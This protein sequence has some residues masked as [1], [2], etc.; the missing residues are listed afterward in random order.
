MK[1]EMKIVIRY[2]NTYVA[3]AIAFRQIS[4]PKNYDLL[5]RAINEM[6]ALENITDSKS[7]SEFVREA[8]EKK[9]LEAEAAKL[10]AVDIRMKSG[11]KRLRE[12]KKNGSN[13]TAEEKEQRDFSIPNAISNAKR[14]IFKD[15]QGKR[16]HQLIKGLRC[17]PVL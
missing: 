8:K 16:A 14:Y 9:R 5:S 2:D 7:A 10:K 13:V 6:E 1:D 12:M 3:N 4:G 15:W 17:K 11:V